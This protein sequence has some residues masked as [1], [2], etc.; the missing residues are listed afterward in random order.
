MSDIRV[1]VG[2]STIT[3]M[4]MLLPSIFYLLLFTSE[5][6]RIILINRMQISPDSP[7]DQRADII[8]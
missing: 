7:D 1:Q 4:T 2:G 8:E 6:K 5:K 3:L